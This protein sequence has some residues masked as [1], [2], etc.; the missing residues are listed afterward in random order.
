MNLTGQER[1]VLKGPL[2]NNGVGQ[3]LAGEDLI[4]GARIA[5]R[6][7][8]LEAM[9]ALAVEAVEALPKHEALPAVVAS[10]RDELLAWVALE[11]PQGALLS[12]EPMPLDHGLWLKVA[13]KVSAALAAGHAAGVVHGELSTD[14]VLL[15]DGRVLLFDLPLVL[16]N[17]LTDRRGEARALAML[18]QTVTYLSVERAKG[19][20]PSEASDVYA[21]AVLLCIAGGA[22]AVPGGNAM[23]KVHRIV[24]EG[25][26]PELPA[27]VPEAHELLQ[28]MLSTEASARPTMPQVVEAVAKLARVTQPY[29]SAAP[30]TEPLPAAVA[31]ASVTT[32][33]IGT[34]PVEAAGSAG[35]TSPAPSEHPL[36]RQGEGSEGGAS[37]GVDSADP[38]EALVAA[39]VSVSAPDPH[40]VPTRQMDSLELQQQQKQMEPHATAPR[41]APTHVLN[42]AR[43]T[44]MPLAATAVPMPAQTA[45]ASPPVPAHAAQPPPPSLK[46]WLPPSE[47]P[48]DAPFKWS[49][50]LPPVATGLTSPEMAVVKP[51]GTVPSMEAIADAMIDAGIPKT[52]ENPLP[53]PSIPPPVATTPP[54]RAREE[55]APMPPPLPTAPPV[56]REPLRLPAPVMIAEV[57]AAA[58]VVAELATAPSVPAPVEASAEVPAPVVAANASV[59]KTVTDIPAAIPQPETPKSLTDTDRQDVL[60]FPNATAPYGSPAAIAQ[61]AN[62]EV[63]QVQLPQLPPPLPTAPAQ[64][65]NAPSGPVQNAAREEAPLPPGILSWISA[66]NPR[67][68][69]SVAAALCLV[70]LGLSL[71]SEMMSRRSAIAELTSTP[72][73][74]DVAKQKA[75]RLKQPP[76]TKQ[77]RAAAMRDA[78]KQEKTDDEY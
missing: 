38:F 11:F 64:R 61:G 55:P 63:M 49:D 37:A 28:K 9:G 16:A 26:K 51:P 31:V 46:A 27:R 21:L 45:P 62:A 66:N 47:R 22:E 78:M 39:G 10:G 23:E 44:P 30:K 50:S 1:F 4:N 18:A 40:A 76:Q 68:I 53:F 35:E 41:P 34:A 72:K 73:P 19:A 17:R 74:A 77:A 24:S 48:S 69:G 15:T 6:K 3:L 12:V 7:M 25:W 20:E 56:A 42:K 29:E 75:D 59:T 33:P 43:R 14:S 60:P 36:P 5:M 13:E 2:R 57:P 8:P 67:L 54:L 58:A 32:A 70:L 52:S 65:R 71:F